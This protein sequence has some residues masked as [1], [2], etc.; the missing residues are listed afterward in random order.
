[1]SSIRD[2][3]GVQNV[4]SGGVWEVCVEGMQVGQECG[5]QCGMAHVVPDHGDGEGDDWDGGWLGNQ[6]KGI[7]WTQVEYCWEYVQGCESKGPG[8]RASGK[9]AGWCRKNQTANKM[10]K[11]LGTNYVNQNM[12]YPFQNSES[13]PVRGSE[14]AKSRQKCKCKIRK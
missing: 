6:G 1:V 7:E 2:R 3:V 14:N 10:Q 8:P 4:V 5:T 9:G 12:Q 13:G 11:N